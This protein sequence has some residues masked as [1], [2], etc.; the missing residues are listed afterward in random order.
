[1]S[2]AVALLGQRVGNR[3]PDV[4]SHP[5]LVTLTCVPIPFSTTRPPP[6]FETLILATAPETDAD[7]TQRHLALCRAL[8]D[9]GM[10]LVEDAAEQARQALPGSPA[11]FSRY[12]LLF[13]RLSH[14]V[15]QAIALEL[16]IL[17]GPKPRP[18]PKPPST[19]TPPP[20]PSAPSPARPHTERLDANFDSAEDEEIPSLL[21]AIGAELGVTL[22]TRPKPTP[23]PHPPQQTAPENTPENAP[24]T[25]PE[26]SPTPNPRPATT[27]PRPQPHPTQKQPAWVPQRPTP[28][29]PNTS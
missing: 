15:R 26:P 16:R 8:A 6:L 20:A 24:E 18:T 2:F 14:A 21:A 13:T 1:M 9:H 19:L 27:H 25:A 7:R 11:E 23:R 12:T 22:E 4:S 3:L 29:A 28:T 17:N 10:K 5:C